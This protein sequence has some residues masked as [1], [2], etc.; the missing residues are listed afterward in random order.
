MKLGILSGRLEG[1]K[2]LT[3]KSASS[4]NNKAKQELKLLDGKYDKINYKEMIGK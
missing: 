2:E 1:S 4:N 3:M